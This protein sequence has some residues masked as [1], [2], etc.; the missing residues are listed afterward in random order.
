M[1]GCSGIVVQS[2]APSGRLTLFAWRRGDLAPAAT[3]GQCAA[4]VVGQYSTLRRCISASS[5]RSW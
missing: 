1:I 2:A 5:S 3:G 4:V